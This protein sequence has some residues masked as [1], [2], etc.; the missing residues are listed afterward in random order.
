M[1]T[2]ANDYWK[3]FKPKNCSIK[4]VG[5]SKEEVF[6]EI[7]GNLVKGGELPEEHAEA[8]RRALL[9]RE[10]LASTGVGRNVAIPHVKLAEL[11]RVV[12]SLSVHPE[13]VDWSALDG[14]PVHIFFTVLRPTRAGEH[15][16][17]D[18]HLAMMQWISRLCREPDFLR[19]SIASK[20]KTELVSLLKEM[21]G[22]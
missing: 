13:G 14:D 2:Q 8:A 1:Q 16:D 5:T 12:A 22:V 21:A 20:T 9:D 11:D 4:I 18:R 17:P 7:V 19:F 3:L 6:E 10:A 15:H